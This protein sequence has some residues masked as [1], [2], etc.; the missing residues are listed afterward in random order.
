MLS[1]SWYNLAIYSWPGKA[2]VELYD[3]RPGKGDL[4]T[5]TFSKKG[6]VAAIFV[7]DHHRV[8]NKVA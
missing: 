1:L 6:I 2:D 5:Q 4:P 7:Y 3:C 8:E